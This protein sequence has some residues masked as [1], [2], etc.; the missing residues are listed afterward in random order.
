GRGDGRTKAHA[1]ALAEAHADLA[2]IVPEK[3]RGEEIAEAVRNLGGDVTILLWDTHDVPGIQK[4]VEQVVSQLGKVDILVND[5]SAEFAKPFAEM[6]VD[7][8]RRALDMNLTGVFFA[9]RAASSHMLER[10][11]GRIINVASALGARAV[12]NS[13]AYCTAMGGL[14]QLT[15]ALALEWAR[16]NIR[17][18]AIAPG[19]IVDSPDELPDTVRRYIPMQRWGRAEDLGG[20][21]VYLASGHC[22]FI[23]GEAIFVDGGVM[24]RT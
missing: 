22:H 2:V 14:L 4:L 20:L 21:L 16:H 9:C 6:S 5:L 7:E 23:T 11:Q 15:R 1:S 13:S 8:W 10:Q 18:N 12:V 17:V 3:A 19:W 24:T